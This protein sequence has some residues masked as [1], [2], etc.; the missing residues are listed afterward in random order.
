MSSKHWKQSASGMVRVFPVRI[1]TRWKH[2]LSLTVPVLCVYSELVSN[3]GHILR[4]SSQAHPLLDAL[5][6]EETYLA[7]NC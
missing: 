6:W 1:G 4:V 5:C 3:T 2:R 7:P